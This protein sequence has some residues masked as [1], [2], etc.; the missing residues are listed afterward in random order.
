MITIDKVSEEPKPR[1]ARKGTLTKKAASALRVAIE[2]ALREHGQRLGPSAVTFLHSILAQLSAPVVR[3]SKKQLDVTDEILVQASFG[4]PLV[5]L[6]G[7]A[8]AD[9]DRL[10]RHAT[11]NSRISSYEEFVIVRLKYKVHEPAIA[12]TLGVWRTPE[13]IKQKTRFD[14]PGELSPIDI[15]G[16]VENDDPDG[17]PPDRG[18]IEADQAREWASVG[19]I[20]DEDL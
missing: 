13:N 10:F 20:D 1:I 19:V 15:D 12:M 9:L 17:L 8:L 3:L 5:I 16:I 4:E 6:E 2:R 18:E 7:N 11:G 14:L